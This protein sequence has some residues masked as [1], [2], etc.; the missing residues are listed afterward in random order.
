[1]KATNQND[2]AM[3]ITIEKGIPIPPPRGGPKRLQKDIAPE[4]I[5][6]DNEEVT[7]N[8]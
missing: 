2:A 1:M 7:A 6:T 3:P 5:D 4:V 8:D